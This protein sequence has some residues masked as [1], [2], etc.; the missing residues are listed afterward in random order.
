MKFNVNSKCCFSWIAA[1][2]L[3]ENSSV[4]LVASMLVSPLMVFS[5]FVPYSSCLLP[6][7][8]NTLNGK[9]FKST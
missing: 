9:Q 3:V 1:I 6:F 7:F 5:K 2:G 4:L 8:N